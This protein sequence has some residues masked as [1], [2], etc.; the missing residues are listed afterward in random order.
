[1]KNL[2]IILFSLVCFAS[3]GQER[4][5]FDLSLSE[6]DTIFPVLLSP[7]IQAIYDSIQ[8]KW[9]IPETDEPLIVLMDKIREL[10]YIVVRQQI[11]LD[12]L[13]RYCIVWDTKHDPH[14]YIIEF[15]EHFKNK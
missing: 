9:G 4:R 1:M 12:S 13:K 5:Y 7:D 10:Q 6:P 15:N 11:Q 8:P 3:C 2:I 14:V